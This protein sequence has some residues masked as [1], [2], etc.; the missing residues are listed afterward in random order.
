MRTLVLAPVTL[1]FFLFIANYSVANH[2]SAVAG[3]AGLVSGCLTAEGGLVK[4]SLGDAP[5]RP[6]T[7]RQVRL[8]FDVSGLT[9]TRQ[10]RVAP[11]LRAPPADTVRDGTALILKFSLPF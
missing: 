10:G 6:C 5:D 8:S 4:L 11:A 2:G 3:E 9:G 7:N 1:V